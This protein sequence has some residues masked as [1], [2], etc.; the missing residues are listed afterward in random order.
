MRFF[1]AV[2]LSA[3][4]L[5]ACAAVRAGSASDQLTRENQLIRTRAALLAAGDPDSL[6]A[7]TATFHG[8]RAESAPQ[9]LALITRAATAASDRRDLAWWQLQLCAAV[10]G[11][12]VQAIEARLQALDP[13]NAAAWSGSLLRGAANKDA[14][15]VAAALGAMAAAQR[16]DVYWNQQVVA[17]SKA[18][19]KTGT[20]EAKTA[21]VVALGAAAAQPLPYK[22]IADVCR[23]EARKRHEML[24]TCRRLSGVLRQGDTYLTESFGLS[25]ARSVW[26]EGSSEYQDAAAGYRVVTYRTDEENHLMEKTGLSNAFAEQRLTQLSLHRTE[27][28]VVL[29]DLASAGVKIDPPPR[30]GLFYTR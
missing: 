15:G 12:E 9:R 19:I 28:E 10:P 23:G 22:P 29:A 11:C 27:Q 17:M 26:A 30:H 18:M 25:L 16:F 4:L 7:A 14:A 13:G 8:N 2:S 3:L 5:L 20:M 1:A 24:M 21:F 6:L